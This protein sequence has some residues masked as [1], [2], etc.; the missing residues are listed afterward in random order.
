MAALRAHNLK[1]LFGQRLLFE[2]LSFEVGKKDRIGLVGAN[3]TGKTTLFKLI[4]GELEAVEGTVTKGRQVKLG[5][6]QQHVGSGGKKGLYEDM[7]SV[8]DYLIEME[9]QLENLARQI[10]KNPPDIDKLIENQQHLSE[11]FEREGGL[12]FRSRARSALLGL[13]FSEEDFDLSLG[14]LSG[15]QLSK[16]NLA[17]LLLGQCDLLLLDEPTNHL[18][19]K[20]VEWLEDFLRSFRGAAIIISHDRYFLDKVSTRTMEIENG[21]ITVYKGNYSD[22][23]KVK[24]SEPLFWKN[25][26]PTKWRKLSALKVL[27]NSNADGTANAI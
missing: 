18:D 8:F 19:I 1:M 21:Q 22:F 12:T 26:M 20:S 2:G 4:T 3:G 10:H 15:G 6:M 23:I 25:S 16:L 17:K 9:A 24:K 27:L 7:L 14:K 11:A 5:Y 13:G